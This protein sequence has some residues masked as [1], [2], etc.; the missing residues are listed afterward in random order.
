MKSPIDKI[1]LEIDKQNINF[2]IEFIVNALFAANKYFNDQEPWKKKDDELRL[3]KI[4]Y[5]TLKMIIKI[6]FILIKPLKDGGSQFIRGVI[7]SD[8][9]PNTFRSLSLCL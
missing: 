9:K 1:R 2:Y 8:K 6:T 4:V 3:N 7:V 5:T